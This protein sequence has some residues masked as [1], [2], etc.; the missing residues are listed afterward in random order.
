MNMLIGVLCEVVKVVSEV[1]KEQLQLNVVKEE[2]LG[3]LRL[4]DQNNNQQLERQEFTDLLGDPEVHATLQK[5]G[6]DVV[7]LVSLAD[8]IFGSKN[9]LSFQDFMDVVLQFRGDNTATVKDIVDLRKLVMTE[10]QSAKE[11][12]LELARFLCAQS[13]E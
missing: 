9:E 1:E 5:V 10:F 11:L 12:H 2:L 13:A 6:V 7:G 3:K 8:F 4:S